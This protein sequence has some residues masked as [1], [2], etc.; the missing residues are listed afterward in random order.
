M[1]QIYCWDLQAIFVS[2]YSFTNNF[3]VSQDFLDD[4][5]FVE[6][7]WTAWCVQILSFSINATGQ[8]FP[9]HKWNFCTLPETRT[10][11][12]ESKRGTETLDI[13]N[14]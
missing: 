12:E 9:Y 10:Y 4:D 6:M 8:A 11:N 14:N 7:S 2:L 5:F 1:F 13:T 3:I